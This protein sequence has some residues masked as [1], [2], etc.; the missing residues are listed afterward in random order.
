MQFDKAGAEAD[1]GLVGHQRSADDSVPWCRHRQQKRADPQ[2]AEGLSGADRRSL[3][4][5]RGRRATGWRCRNTPT[6]DAVTTSLEGIR[7]EAVSRCR[8]RVGSSCACRPSPF[9]RSRNDG[10]GQFEFVDVGRGQPCRQFVELIEGHVSGSCVRPLY[11]SDQA[12]R[13]GEPL[14][15]LLARGDRFVPR[16]LRRSGCGCRSA[17]DRA[18]RGRP[19]SRCRSSGSRRRAVHRA[20]ARSA[21]RSCGTWI[22]PGTMPCER[23]FDRRDGL[24]AASLPGDSRSGRSAA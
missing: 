21:V 11:R 3:R 15:A 10:P 13:L 1:D 17:P 24:A 22:T 6:E 19:R 4:R 9:S 8:S 16:G 12:A 18:A 7:P 20:S 23:S 14:L 5:Q 2:Q